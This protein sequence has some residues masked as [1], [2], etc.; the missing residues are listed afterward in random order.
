MFGT[1]AGAV[2]DLVATRKAA[3][4]GFALVLPDRREEP[5][6]TDLHRH[7]IVAVAEGAGHPAAAGI[8]LEDVF[9]K[10]TQDGF[11]AA[12]ALN[13]ALLTMAVEHDVGAV[14][15]KRP[16]GLELPLRPLLG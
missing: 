4:D 13:R 8:D 10:P 12:C 14:F 16:G 15:V 2:L 1:L 5:L 9:R 7:V 3:G 11:G 6:L